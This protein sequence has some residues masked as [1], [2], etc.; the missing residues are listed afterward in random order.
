MKYKVGDTVL[1]QGVVTEVEERKGDDFH[2]KVKFHALSDMMFWL[3]D[4]EIFELPKPDKT[5]EQGLQDAWGLVRRLVANTNPSKLIDM[6]K[7]FGASDIVDILDKYTPQEVLAKLKAYEK[8]T[9][10]KVGDVVSNGKHALL[11]VKK[12]DDYFY[13]LDKDGAHIFLTKQNLEK[14]ELNKT[15]KH[16][17]LEGIFEQIKGE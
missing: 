11:C 17:D 6:G 5:Y 16:I 2:T 1:I 8:S 7:F 9:E 3:K 12:D 10:I 15:G 4:D 14:A 13:F